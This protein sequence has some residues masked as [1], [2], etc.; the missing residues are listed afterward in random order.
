[1]ETHRG[2][3]EILSKPVHPIDGFAKEELLQRLGSLSKEEMEV[4]VTIIPSELI[5]NEIKRRFEN[6]QKFINEVKGSMNAM[7]CK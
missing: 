4:L 1:M 7:E 5:W 3:E 2:A 6:Q